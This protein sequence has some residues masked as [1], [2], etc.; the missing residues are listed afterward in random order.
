[1]NPEF[2]KEQDFKS[3]AI[4]D[5]AILPIFVTLVNKRIIGRFIYF[6]II[7][8][9][10]FSIF[11]L[12]EFFMQLLVAIT[13]TFLFV[14]REKPILKYLLYGYFFVTITLIFQIPLKL[15]EIRFLSSTIEDVFIPVIILIILSILI[16]EIT[17][18]FAIK[19]FVKT[20][21]F[22]NGILFGM[23]WS[24]IESIN[25]FSI[26]L[27]SFIFS[28]INVTISP[29]SIIPDTLPYF[30][31]VYFFIINLSITVLIIFSIIK[32]NLHYLIFSNFSY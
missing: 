30:S 7:I 8:N 10:M 27:Y 9:F 5:Y 26:W 23:G 14:N 1:M 11:I 13:I 4:P 19:R 31:F 20:K 15:F 6:F 16:T 2:Q 32:K 29:V 25:F 18:Y 3:C 17:K 12:L 24:T 28:L 21:S 22:K